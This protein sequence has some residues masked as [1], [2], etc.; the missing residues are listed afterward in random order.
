MINKP[1]AD[2]ALIVHLQMIG[3]AAA[4][5]LQSLSEQ[6]GVACQFI[7]IHD[8]NSGDALYFAHEFARHD[9]RFSVHLQM[10]L[11]CGSAYNYGLQLV[12]STY[13]V[14]LNGF[15]VL[16]ANFCLDLVSEMQTAGADI[17]YCDINEQ[18]WQLPTHEW[19]QVGSQLFNK[20]YRS[21]FIREHTLTFKEQVWDAELRF[22]YESLLTNPKLA[23][24]ARIDV[25]QTTPILLKERN[26]DHCY[27]IFQHLALLSERANEPQKTLLFPIFC[28]AIFIQAIPRFW[29]LHENEPSVIKRQL[30]YSFHFLAQ[31]YPDWES[32]LKQ[33]EFGTD[34]V[35][36]YGKPVSRKLKQLNSWRWFT[37]W[38]RYRIQQMWQTV[39]QK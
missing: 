35:K 1:Q 14:F 21:A 19:L 32:R 30:H 3:N 2:I 28:E 16:S 4:A 12:E 9:N 24:I 22:N 31:Q 10:G 20:A 17:G 26:V 36:Q 27:D 25:S 39:R 34:F 29:Q 37:I 15:D 7:I 11:G 8:G 5:C 18:R 23:H 13:V 6:G 38:Y 33:L